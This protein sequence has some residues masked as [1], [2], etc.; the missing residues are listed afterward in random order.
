M[1]E[2]YAWSMEMLVGSPVRML[3]RSD[4]PSPPTKTVYRFDG[5]LNDCVVFVP[6]CVAPHEIRIGICQADEISGQRLICTNGDTALLEPELSTLEDAAQP[7]SVS[8]LDR[9]IPVVIL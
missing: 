8:H 3:A 4:R 5:M 7:N 9:I 6:S 1:S 2:T